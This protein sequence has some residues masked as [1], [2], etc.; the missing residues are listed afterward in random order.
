MTANIR[1]DACPHCHNGFFGGRFGADV[2][3]VNG[4]L[5]DIDVAHEGYQRDVAYPP[6]PC[7]AKQWRNGRKAG[8][9][10]ECQSRLANWASMGEA[11][12]ATVEPQSA[13]ESPAKSPATESA[14]GRNA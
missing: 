10:A 2:E 3:C 6:A 9:F 12:E 4:V 1:G 14:T 7:I 11:D 8:W 5:I 13:A